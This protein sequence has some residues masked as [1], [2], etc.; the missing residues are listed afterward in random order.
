M[1]V[2][3]VYCGHVNPDGSTVCLSCGRTLPPAPS[4]G[5]SS[6]GQQQQQPYGQQQQPQ[7]PQS[8]GTAPPNQPAPPSYP[9]ASP[10][11][12]S[13][14]QPPPQDP[15]SQWQGGYGGQPSS[16]GT[17]PPGPAAPPSYGN[18]Q[19]YGASSYPPPPSFGEAPAWGGQPQVFGGANPEAQSA[20]QMALIALVVS[21][22]GILVGVCC[23]SGVVI[24]PLGAVLGFVARGKLQRNGVQEG[25]GFA[26][27]AI[28][29]GIFVFCLPILWTVLWLA[30]AAIN[31]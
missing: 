23:W 22:V 17:P 13:Y 5:P 10:Y 25:Q 1:S 24:G 21:C 8:W 16:F 26:L 31:Q 15:G 18:Q 4:G 20:R 2:N 30:I 27:A 6:Y 12:S 9:P 7:Q 19:G 11:G 3:C 29:I 14:P 28:I